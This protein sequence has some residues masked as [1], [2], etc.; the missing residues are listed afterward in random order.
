MPSKCSII[1]HDFRIIKEQGKF[2]EEKCLD[3]GVVVVFKEKG[4][5]EDKE[6]ARA[7]RRDFIQPT[8]RE[9]WNLAYPNKKIVDDPVRKQEMRETLH[10]KF[11]KKKLPSVAEEYFRTYGGQDDLAKIL[12]WHL[13]MN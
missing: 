11:G 4:W 9:A 8:D 2:K 6:Y 12:K 1:G 5:Q 13:S 10:E 3:C 7:H